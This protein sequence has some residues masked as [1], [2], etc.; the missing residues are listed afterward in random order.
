MICSC[1]SQEALLDGCNECNFEV[2]K[3]INEEKIVKQKNIRMLLQSLNNYCLKHNV[4][5]AEWI[6]ETLFSLLENNTEMLLKELELYENTE[7]F[8]LFLCQIKNP[9]SDTIPMESIKKKL[10]SHKMKYTIAEDIINVL[11]K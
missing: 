2:L 8:S 5:Y 9:L 6:N 4:E 7:I 3:I 11:G 1:K 10:M